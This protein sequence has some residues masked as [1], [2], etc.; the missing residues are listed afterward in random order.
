[1]IIVGTPATIRAVA[2]QL[3]S[4]GCDA[5]R[6]VGAV[7]VDP[8]ERGA[9]GEVEV[10]GPLALL[11][12]ICRATGV[13]EAL[14]SIPEAMVEAR[15]RARDALA[16]IGVRERSIP[17]I[18][19]ILSDTN[20][21]GSD[22]SL[23]LDLSA[24]IGRTPRQLDESPVR[25]LLAG[26]RVLI[27]GAGGSIGSELSLRCAAMGAGEVILMDRSENALFEI[28]RRVGVECPAVPRRAVLHD[29]VDLDGTRRRLASL[30]PN[31]VFHAAAHKHVPMMED[32]PAAALDNNLFGTRSIADASDAVGV[33]R[34]VMISTDKAVNPVSVMGATKRL[35]EV[36]VRSLNGAGEPTPRFRLVRFGNVLGSA[37]SVLPIWSRQIAEGGPVTVTHPEMTRYFMTIPEAAA[38]VMQTAAM[39]E[40]LADVFV[41]DMGEPVRIRDLAERFIRAHGLE[42]AW[43][44]PHGPGAH[45]RPATTSAFAGTIRVRFTGPRPGEKLHEE[46]AHASEELVPTAVP[47]ILSWHGPRPLPERVK[48][49]IADL[50]G[51]RRSDNAA[52]V[53]NA[54]RRQVEGVDIARTFPERPV[55]AA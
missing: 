4:L 54:I 32:H 28:D 16:A 30:R 19:D 21:P 51:L 14:V 37:C 45:S 35:A 55:Q 29:V 38:L 20:R 17:P 6:I 22:R 13:R 7:S 53:L 34:F 18:Q 46:L 2:A 15:S 39:D 8:A 36:Y 27:T 3:A 41:L 43:E 10:L 12:D 50:V 5:P 42:P 44:D 24:L 25:D 11:P 26:K 49:M 52:M 47:G 40:T 31:V 9:C 48:K 33:E 23:T 1:M